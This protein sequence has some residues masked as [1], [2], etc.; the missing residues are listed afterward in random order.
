MSKFWKVCLFVMAVVVCLVIWDGVYDNKAIDDSVK[1]I[2]NEIMTHGLA[3]LIVGA[4]GLSIANKQQ[5]QKTR[6]WIIKCCAYYL[7]FQWC[8][9][10]GL[11]SAG[12]ALGAKRLIDK[13]PYEKEKEQNDIPPATSIGNSQTHNT[14]THV[15]LS[16][17][18]ETTPIGH[19]GIRGSEFLVQKSEDPDEKNTSRELYEVYNSYIAEAAADSYM[20]NKSNIIKQAKRK[21]EHKALIS[22]ALIVAFVCL[23]VVGFIYADGGFD[24][25]I[26]D[27]NAQTSSQK[28]NSSSGMTYSEWRAIKRAEEEASKTTQATLTPV[29]EPASGT[30]L[31]GSRVT[32][33][34]E[35]TIKT[36]NHSCVVKLK[37]ILGETELSFYVRKNTTVT[38][39]V[40]CE[41]LYVYF[42][43]GETW[44]GY[45]HLFGENTAY[46]KD[47]KILDFTNYTWEY[48]LYPVTNGNFTQTEISENEF[49][50]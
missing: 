4:I 29:A 44:Y 22:F 30:I 10:I 41:Y 36:S 48:T 46:S 33:E 17:A 21:S 3:V 38:V 6:E 9:L 5:S 45:N 47:D 25:L 8:G 20:S 12:I 50:E 23:V 28:D 14:N 39:N 27:V 16:S 35:L 37:N 42:A 19:R 26:A 11:L 43:S 34:S 32:D 24:G 15:C 2:V 49:K 7:I 1:D 40:P 13:K 18:D 31:S